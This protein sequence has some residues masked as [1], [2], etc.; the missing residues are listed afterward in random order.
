MKSP[1]ASTYLVGNHDDEVPFRVNQ[2][3]PESDYSEYQTLRHDKKYRQRQINCKAPPHS[4][5][6]RIRSASSGKHF[7]SVHS[8]PAFS[9]FNRELLEDSEFDHRINQAG[10]ESDY[11]EHQSLRHD[12]RYR[13]WQINYKAPPHPDKSRIRSASSGKHF[14]S[15]R[16]SAAFSVFNRELLED[17]EF[18]LHFDTFDC[19]NGTVKTL[20]NIN[21]LALKLAMKNKKPDQKNQNPPQLF[22]VALQTEK[23]NHEVKYP[24]WNTREIAQPAEDDIAIFKQNKVSEG[25][26]IENFMFIKHEPP[27]EHQQSDETMIISATSAQNR[28]TYADVVQLEVSKLNQGF[29]QPHP[30]T[31]TE[32]KTFLK[33]KDTR[34]NVLTEFLQF[35][36][37]SSAKIHSGISDAEKQSHLKDDNIEMNAVNAGRGNENRDTFL[38][39]ELVQCLTETKVSPKMKTGEEV[40]LGFSQINTENKCSHQETGGGDSVLKTANEFDLVENERPFKEGYPNNLSEPS[41]PS[42]N[43]ESD[44]HYSFDQVMSCAKAEFIAVEGFDL[45]TA[46]HIAHNLWGRRKQ[47]LPYTRMFTESSVPSSY[48]EVEAY[49]LL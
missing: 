33:I 13:Q 4:D 34:K 26:Q 37:F 44:P 12:K 41:Y 10:P 32:M 39:E 17:S 1:S 48:Y 49:F 30:I 15:V 18:D 28:K 29:R 47:R 14:S 36:N 6:S 2:A 11:S 16:R 25:T 27:H 31:V 38:F 5:K 3:G 40:K 22:D 21:S 43:K 45:E 42:C 20:D 24:L 19:V 7:S 23:C 9:V 8:N 46:F 35:K